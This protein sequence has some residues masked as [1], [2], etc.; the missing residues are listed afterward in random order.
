MKKAFKILLA[1]LAIALLS[2]TVVLSVTASGE[3]DPIT[4]P[5]GYY[6][7][8][9]DPSNNTLTKYKDPTQFIS[10]SKAATDNSIIRLLWD[11]EVDNHTYSSNGDKQNWIEFTGNKTY[12]I[13]LNGRYFS[14]VKCVTDGY[15][16]SI[17]VG[18]N[19]TLNIFSSKEGGRLYNYHKKGVGNANALVWLRSK[20][21]KLNLGE[22]T[23]DT[24]LNY[25]NLTKTSYDT[26]D[27]FK[28]VTSTDTPVT[29]S[30][31]N[32]SAYGG[33]LVGVIDNGA[34]D[35]NIKVNINGG[36]Y[37]QNAAAAPFIVCEANETAI[38]TINVENAKLI[39]NYKDIINVKSGAT[40]SLKFKNCLI[41]ST[42]TN[43]VSYNSENASLTFDGCRFYGNTGG[44]GDKITLNDCMF[45]NS[46]SYSTDK[47]LIKTYVTESFDLKN[48]SFSYNDDGS[49]NIPVALRPYMG[50]VEKIMPK[51]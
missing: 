48:Y 35:A 22:I 6:F 27:V 14:Y 18:E 24:T 45:A 5:D 44:I 3:K 39:S 51:R 15:Q 34:N 20:N 41:Y 42:A 31:D 37:I 7:E 21:A 49:V 19:T 4:P 33:A 16:V 11:I 23:F 28:G 26:Y 32:I 12:N 2:C 46:A 10:K 43:A 30:G 1:I 36:T 40:A 9:Y 38:S 29:Y 13:D 17:S 8:I 50:G 47:V 25:N